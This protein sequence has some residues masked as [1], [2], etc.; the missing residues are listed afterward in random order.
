MPQDGIY[1][2]LGSNLSEPVEQVC[3]AVRELGQLP[4]VRLQSASGLYRS[5]PMGDMDQPDYINAAVCVC[6]DLAP[7]QML[8][9]MQ[10]IER[11]HGREEAHGHWAARTLDLDL[12]LWGKEC[13]DDDALTLPHPGLHERAFVLAPLCELDADLQV[14]GRGAVSELLRQ[15]KYAQVDRVGA[16]PQA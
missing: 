9:E 11:R 5:P 2:G 10:A 13:R 16:C 14:P 7:E 15:C 1:I 8:Q 4:K 12:L 3:L 6:A